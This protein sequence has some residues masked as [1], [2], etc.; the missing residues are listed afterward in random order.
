M[1]RYRNIIKNKYITKPI[2][3]IKENVSNKTDL[4]N[5]LDQDIIKESVLSIFDPLETWIEHFM[6]SPKLAGK[7]PDKIKHHAIQ[8]YM[9]AKESN[10][11]YINT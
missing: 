2:R 1:I 10:I 11:P 8:A 5:E 7:S 4:D 9:K 3:N 6:A